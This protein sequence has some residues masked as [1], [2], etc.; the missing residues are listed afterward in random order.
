M[1]KEKALKL[2]VELFNT[3]D[4]DLKHEDSRSEAKLCGNQVVVQC[5]K[6]PSLFYHLDKVVR[7]TDTLGLL[8][9]A[10]CVDNKLIIIVF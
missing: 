7:I 4:G 3:Y 10:K 8:E 5:V 1:T 6:D 9:Y 2:F